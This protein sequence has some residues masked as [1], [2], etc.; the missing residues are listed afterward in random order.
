MAV[1][2]IGLAS[3]EYVYDLNWEFL[4]G[5]HLCMTSWWDSTVLLYS[6]THTKEQLAEYRD[7]LDEKYKLETSDFWDPWED[8]ETSLMYRFELDDVVILLDA[9]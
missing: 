3:G 8:T 7:K 6:E 5:K 1:I 9:K 2:T 4:S